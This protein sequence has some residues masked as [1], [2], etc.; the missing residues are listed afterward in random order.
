MPAQYP[1]IGFPP[2]SQVS[3]LRKLVNNTAEMAEGGGPGGGVTSITAGAGIS[4]DQPTGAVTISA[5][6]TG[7]VDSVFGRTGIVTAEVD[8][9]SAF[10][11][12]LTA[13]NSWT[14]VNTFAGSF[15]FTPAT[16]VI[17]ANSGAWDITKGFS[18]ATNGANTTLVMSAAGTNGQQLYLNAVNSDTASHT[19]TIDNPAGADPTFTA[20]AGST[21]AIKLQSNGTSWTIIGG[22]PT[23]NDISTATPVS[24]D[25]LAFWDTSAGV[26]AKATLNALAAASG[27]T[28]ANILAGVLAGN[29]TLGESAG[30]IVLDPA[31][32]AD[33]TWS[34]IMEEGT[35]GTALAFGD[36]CYFQAAD[37]RWELVDADAEATSGPLMLGMCVLAAAGDGSATNILRWGK[38]RADANFPTLTIGAPAYAGLT[39]GDI[40]VAQPNATDDVIRIVGYGVTADVLLFQPSNDYMVHV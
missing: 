24:T 4:V 37:S 30:Q 27:L 25:L 29:I 2:D 8:D 7:A 13:P 9:Y 6:G 31:L 26:T 11:G 38:I 5:T 18:V 33:G 17:A 14:G 23:I 3:L 20:A 10:Y 1:G 12:Q 16:I 15:I 19:W 21:T 32:S 36:L 40:Q 22:A 34:G 35:A 39:P 28:F